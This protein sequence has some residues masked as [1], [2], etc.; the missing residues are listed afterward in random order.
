MTTTALTRRIALLAFIG[1]MGGGLVFPILPA[2]GLELGIPAFMIGLI[3]SANRIS[4]LVFNIPVG[5]MVS[6]LGARRTLGWALFIESVSMLAYS[7]ALQ[8]GEASW[9]FLG[10]RVLFG[11]GTAFLLVGAQAAVLSLSNRSDRGRKTS[12]V[13]VAIS[14]AMPMGL[15]IG[16]VLADR[17]SDNV[18]FLTGA[19][20][21]FAGS[22]LAMTTLPAPAVLSA[23]SQQRQHVRIK[24][25][26]QSDKLPFLA[27][28]WGYNLLI[29][30]TMQGALLATMVILVKD[31]D[32]HLLDMQAKGTSGL[33]M[34]ILIAF[35]ALMA[36]RIGRAIDRLPQRT[37]LLIPSLAGLATGFAVVAVAQ[38]LIPL[39]LGAILVGT[40][41]NGVTLPMLSLLGDVTDDREHGLAVGIYQFFGDIGGTIGPIAGIEIGLH[42]G[43]EPL[44]LILAALT[45]L[46]LPLGFW[47]RRH[48]RRFN[49]AGRS[50]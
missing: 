37:S 19:A 10:G 34:A 41:Y 22:L 15:V 17:F 2:L 13:R 47:I 27:A 28:A 29:F 4:R 48:E 30:L 42:Y 39:I 6:R 9:W 36:F 40:F 49:K 35:S 5:R 26:L 23:E 1:G 18:A 50:R 7:A 20:L 8:F 16:G 3:L 45:V 43:T 38:T 31:R 33:I 44:Y 32:I 21:T 14:T 46:T 11:I 24:T 25:L 12:M